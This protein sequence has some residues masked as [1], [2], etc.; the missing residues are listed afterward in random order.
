MKLEGN[1]KLVSYSR[2]G[3]VFHYR[4]A[5][6]RC[7]RLLNPKINLEMVVIEGSKEREKAGEYVIDVSE[8]YKDTSNK[9]RIEYYQLKH[10]TV[11][12]DTPFTLSG[13]KDTIIGFSKRY[14]Q[15]IEE[16]TRKKISFTIITNRKIDET[17]KQ[18]LAII[19]NG[20][21]VNRRFSDT[22]EKY[23]NLSGNELITFCS[24]LHLED[25]EGDYNIQK[26]ELRIEMSRLQP[27]SIDPA[28][29]DS[30]VSLV[31][32]RV[33]PH[34]NGEIIKENVLRP[35]GVSSE[36]QLFPAPPVF[37]KLEKL[38]IRSQYGELLDTIKTE[39]NPII[40]NAEGGVGKSI[41]S[42]YLKDV[43]PKEGSLAIA[44][45]CFGAG[46][47]RSRSE[48][49]HRHR[50]ALVQISNELASLGLCERILIK[51]TTLESDVMRGF[52]ER[53]NSS[54]KSLR[55]VNNSAVLVIIIDASDNAEMAAHE[56]ND[57]C[58]AN[59]LLR[60]EFPEG[61]QL[62]LSSRPERTHLLKPSG[63][64]V[65]LNLLPF[66]KEETFENLKKWFPAVKET[67]AIEF[68]RLT[69]G[70]P[71][72][73]MNSISNGHSSMNELLAYLGP[74]VTTV[75]KQI[76]H[77]LNNAVQ[78]IKDTLP[79]D[80]QTRIDKICT[81]LAS[82]PPNI[83]IQVL[84]QIAEVTLEDVKSFVADIGRSLWLLDSSVQF[85]D[86][87]TE[88]WF[89]NTYLASR[90]NFAN[91][92]DILKPLANSNTYIALALPQ[93]YLQ[94]G[95]YEQLID[96]ALSDRLLPN[97]NPIDTR[98]VLVYRLQFAFKAAL[99]S[100]N[101]ADAIKLALRAGEEIAGDQRQQN[102][103]QRNIDL[104]PKFQ[105]KSKVQEI[106]FKGLLKSEW[107]GSENVYTSSLLS[108]I[109]E[110][111]G[112]ANSYLRSAINWLHIYFDES[113][114]NQNKNRESKVDNDDI[115][116]LALSILNL[117][118]AVSCL[119]FLSRF[120]PKRSMFWIMKR[121]IS[122]LIDSSRFKEIDEILNLTKKSK[123]FVIAIVSELLEVGRFAEI[124]HLERC[125]KLLS[126]PKTR[127]KKPPE[128]F[129]DNTITDSIIS[130]LEVCLYRK[131]NTEIILK[132]L[133]YYVPN[134]TSTGIGLRFNSKERTLYLK[135]LCIRNVITQNLKINLDELV[136]SAYKSDDKDRDYS[137]DI[138]N[139][140]E[141]VGGLYPWFLLRTQVIASN[142]DNL[143]ESSKQTNQNS[144]EAY[145][146]RYRDYDD[147]PT[148][149]AGVASSI[150]IYCDSWN[151]EVIDQYFESYLQ[152]NSSFK[153]NQR[154]SLL[155]SGNRI[156]HLDSILSE[157]E[158]TTYELIKKLKGLSP[159]EIAD[160]FVSLSRAVLSRSK[161][162]AAVY[163]NDATT[164]VSKFGDE[165]VQRWE[166]VV[167]L[168]RRSAPECSD[169][170]AY[171]FIR[172]AELVGEYVY[173]EKHWNRSGAIITCTKMSPHIGISAMSRWRDR[174]IGRF[175]YQ[176][177]SLLLH[178]VKSEII[179]PL[180]GW[181][182]ARFLKDHHLSELLSICLEKKSSLELK[183]QIFTDAFELLR[184]EES[185][186]NYLRDMKSI[187][188][189]HQITVKELEQALNYHNEEDIDSE[190]FKTQKKEEIGSKSKIE[191][192]SIF[193]EVNIFEPRG[194]DMLTDRFTKE[195]NKERNNNY[196]PLILL[197]KEILSR[198]NAEQ[199][200]D[201]IDLLFNSD[202]INHYDLQ[203]VL[204]FIP[205]SWK[206]KVS[207]KS[208][209]SSIL[210]EFGY[211]YAHDLIND[212]SF[213]SALRDLDIDFD[214]SLGFRK[215]IFK[216]LSKGQE[217]NN[218][219]LLFNFVER[220]VD[221]ISVNE[222]SNLTEYALS[223][224][225]LHVEDNLGDGPW[226]EWLRVSNDIHENIAGFIWSA[227]GSPRSDT[228]WRACHTVK[229]LADFNCTQILN[230][231]VDWMNK[232]HVGAYGSKLFPFYNLHARQY[233][234]IAFRR[235]SVDMSTSMIPYKE[236]FLEYSY[237]EPHILIQK[238]SADIALN[239]EKAIP[240]TYNK[241]EISRLKKIGKSKYD[242][243][244]EKFGYKINSYLH[245]EGLIDTSLDYFFGWDFDRYWYEPLGKVFGI[246][247]EQIQEICA[248]V[249]VKEWQQ[250][251]KGG[252]NNDPR[253]NLW[254]SSSDRDTWHNKTS[255]PKTDNLDFYLSYHSMLVSAA[256][257]VENMPVVVTRDRDNKNPWEEWLSRHSLSKTD[258][259]WLAD[260]RDLLPLVRPKWINENDHKN[261]RIDIKESDFLNSIKFQANDQTWLNIDGG[262]TERKDSR[263]ETYSISIAL[264]CKQASNA[265]L[266]ALSTCSD[267][268]DYKLP[269]YKEDNMEI[270]S[271]I[272]Q[273]KGL[274]VNPYMDRGI[275][276]FDP[277]GKD[278]I[279]PCSSIGEEFIERLDLSMN[280]NGK[281]W[282]T[283]DGKL[284]LKCETWNSK[285]SAYD[286]ESE[287]SG[288]CLSASFTI[289][290]RICEIYSCDLI[291]K[292][293]ISRDIQYRYRSYEKKN[294]YQYIENHRVYLLSKDGT[295][296]NTTKDYR[297]R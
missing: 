138:R 266:S 87:P 97:E 125:L 167:A 85:R 156:N 14:R 48:P 160:N 2:A 131:M 41:F 183:T 143:H 258:G 182:M 69:S 71:R 56:F 242:I 228:R 88:T 285:L 76:E 209:W 132:V 40:I 109:E 248:N 105:D 19:I 45:D 60:E 186:S 8:Y 162:D 190:T 249:I 57:S 115:L 267:P 15:H 33:L 20:G 6:R 274:I 16:K 220:A 171:R 62:V 170:L 47:Y 292:V 144:L 7:L 193:N 70:N 10:S 3:D 283:N 208:K 197:H 210:Y 296:R 110:Y 139:F 236:I 262:W 229:K 281:E 55:S 49:R 44:Y 86:E 92:I 205:A 180:I 75:E 161:D 254:N 135:A 165:L 221:F 63:S 260:S 42:Q 256:K 223:R 52:L 113:N 9:E 189:K 116:E 39:N 195:V 64:I 54:I 108:E 50:D 80:Y 226:E 246:S 290:N 238:F 293:V 32:E 126:E 289:L 1:N 177:H 91:Y 149:I 106:A 259:R 30:I 142:V 277:Y 34:S 58:F 74:S 134:K 148:E 163:F 175:E 129:N 218:A 72:V 128:L 240:E 178:L 173:R 25:G 172:C 137:D 78:K 145:K 232:N 243:Q 155:R 65:Q 214:L 5:A 187:A 278:I 130:F 284:A 37:E 211:R 202:E 257:L 253:V 276:E 150:L 103:F 24:S 201:F 81:G 13:L 79:S 271:G 22:L 26:E 27:G 245:K 51:D 123:Y 176:F 241:S 275:D 168:G 272:F 279:F 89:R 212:Y 127:I 250:D 239:I 204:K 119:K 234:L 107:E 270:D 188:D 11:R 230:G 100:E 288:M 112:E 141:L 120:K 66:S 146:N 95:L 185:S 217:F 268:H 43:L 231:L 251:A 53:L 83:P 247:G 159:E 4:W 140:K 291:I 255:Y 93:L 280:I 273:L 207:F 154:I 294:D 104:L 233:L 198:I 77:Q 90:K 46:K 117:K 111:H 29:L 216:G 264:V 82:L 199:L 28:Q 124:T 98:N 225:E 136:P 84:A 164:T 114:K 179:N 287:Q 38:T 166:A 101:H 61:C 224:F 23:T 184:K 174:E 59:E 297:I 215:A 17:F 67:E 153:I 151:L 263:Y 244:N 219:G 157:L 194:L 73:Q 68:H 295:L 94:A 237:K 235:I 269:D 282:Y 36:R 227:L 118:G 191:W 261:W 12:R 158:N 222:A 152:N 147:L 102:L 252:F 35:F 181:S 192:D 203:Q 206:N 133:D 265:L 18:N 21:K 99:R 31:Q 196:R 96:I 200:N 122:Q 286:E 213:N 121:L 169:E